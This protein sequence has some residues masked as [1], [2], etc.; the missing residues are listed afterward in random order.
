MSTSKS[1]K[2]HVFMVFLNFKE[3]S[4]EFGVDFS[5]FDHPLAPTQG[6]SDDTL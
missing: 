5:N 4:Y 2:K 6:I 3:V 1:R